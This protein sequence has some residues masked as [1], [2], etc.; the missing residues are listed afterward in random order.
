MKFIDFLYEEI[1]KVVC[2]N[3]GYKTKMSSAE[4]RK[5]CPKCGT[6]MEKK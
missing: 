1:F 4:G 3:C 5:K 2:P 6:F